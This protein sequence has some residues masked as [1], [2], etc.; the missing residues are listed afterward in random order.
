MQLA[1]RR[2]NRCDSEPNGPHRLI[3]LGA[4]RSRNPRDRNGN[5]AGENK[6]RTSGHGLGTLRGDRTDAGRIKNVARDT[7]DV[8]LTTPPLTVAEEPET[9][10]RAAATSPPVQDS[11]VPTRLPEETPSKTTSPARRERS[12]S[13]G[14]SMSKSESDKLLTLRNES[15]ALYEVINAAPGSQDDGGEQQDVRD[16]GKTRR[17]DTGGKRA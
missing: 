5:V 17:E 4:C 2:P 9:E 3:R 8:V 14:S 16:D 13:E 10:V 11:A 7:E 1:L 15:P 6:T 12:S